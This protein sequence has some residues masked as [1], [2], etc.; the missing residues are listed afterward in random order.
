LSPGMLPWG[1]ARGF[2]PLATRHGKQPPPQTYPA[3]AALKPGM[4]QGVKGLRVG[5]VCR[6]LFS[7]WS[8][9]P[10]GC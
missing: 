7:L 3:P 6:I 5:S 1:Q 4:S 2:S 10:D 8:M 9:P